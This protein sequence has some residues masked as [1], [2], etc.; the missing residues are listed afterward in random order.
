M[1]SGQHQRTRPE[2]ATLRAGRNNYDN[3]YM[4]AQRDY[5]GG[6]P[7]NIGVKGCQGSTHTVPA[8]RE[9]KIRMHS[10]AT[11][12]PQV[13]FRRHSLKHRQ[14][15]G[16][17]HAVPAHRKEKIIHHQ[18]LVPNAPTDHHNHCRHQCDS[19]RCMDHNVSCARGRHSRVHS[20][21]HESILAPARHLQGVATAH[22]AYV[23]LT[24]MGMHIAPDISVSISSGSGL[25]LLKKARRHSTGQDS[26]PASH[27]IAFIHHKQHT[28]DEWI[29]V[30]RKS[31]ASVGSQNKRHHSLHR[32][33]GSAHDSSN[34]SRAIPVHG[35]GKLKHHSNHVANEVADHHSYYRHQ[36]DTDDSMDQDISPGH[37][38]CEC[39]RQAR[40][41]P[42]NHQHALIKSSRNRPLDSLPPMNLEDVFR[43]PDSWRVKKHT[44]F[45]SEVHNNTQASGHAHAVPAHRETKIKRSHSCS[46]N[47][48]TDHH[49]HCRHQC[50]SEGCADHNSS[51]IHGGRQPIS[52]TR[53]VSVSPRQQ[54]GVQQAHHAYVPLT[55]TGLNV[56]TK[57]SIAK[58]RKK[59]YRSSVSRRNYSPQHTKVP[60]YGHALGGVS[61]KESSPENVWTIAIDKNH[62]HTHR[63]RS[64]RASQGTPEM[65]LD[66]LFEENDGN[67]S[68]DS[69]HDVAPEYRKG[70]RIPGHAHA[71]PAHRDIRL[72]HHHSH[73]PN[74][75]ADHHNHWRHQCDSEIC[76]DLNDSHAHHGHP[77]QK[78]HAHPV[79]PPLRQR[80]YVQQAHIANRV[81]TTDGLRIPTKELPQNEPK[82]RHHISVP[83]RNYG[84]Q[85]VETPEYVHEHDHPMD[86]THP[87][88]DSW[89]LAIDKNHKHIHRTRAHRPPVGTPEMHLDE[90]FTLPDSERKKNNGH[91]HAFPAH[92]E[93]RLKRHYS[94]IPNAPM[95]RHNHWRH[96]CEMEECMSHDGSHAHYGQ[97]RVA[98]HEPSS[99]DVPLRQ[100]NGIHKAHPAGVPLTSAGLHVP[101]EEPWAMSPKKKHHIGV[102]SRH[103]GAQHEKKPALMI[104]HTTEAEADLSS[105]QWILAIDKNHKHTHRTR[106]HRIQMGTPEMHLDEI[107]G[108][109][110]PVKAH[111]NEHHD[112]R[113]CDEVGPVDAVKRSSILDSAPML[114]ESVSWVLKERRQDVEDDLEDHRVLSNADTAQSSNELTHH[115]NHLAN[116]YMDRHNHRRHQRKSEYG[117]VHDSSHEHPLSSRLRCTPDSPVLDL[118][119]LF[120]EPASWDSMNQA[121]SFQGK[122]QTRGHAHAVPTHRHGKNKRN[123]YFLPNSPTDHHNH[124]RHRRDREEYADHNDIDSHRGQPPGHRSHHEVVA[125]VRHQR[126]ITQA[127][128]AGTPLV[129]ES[130]RK[131][132]HKHKKSH[133]RDHLEKSIP[134]SNSTPDVH[135]YMSSRDGNNDNGPTQYNEWTVVTHARSYHNGPRDILST[136]EN[137][138]GSLYTDGTSLIPK[139]IIVAELNRHRSYHTPAP[140]SSSDHAYIQQNAHEE[141]QSPSIHSFSR[142]SNSRQE[143][144]KNANAVPG[145]SEGRKSNHQLHYENNLDDHHNHHRQQCGDKYFSDHND[146]HVHSRSQHGDNASPARFVHYSTPHHRPVGLYDDKYSRTADSRVHSH[147]ADSFHGYV[148]NIPKSLEKLSKVKLHPGRH[149]FLRRRANVLSRFREVDPVNQYR[150]AGNYRAP[151]SVQHGQHG[152][153]SSYLRRP[154]LVQHPR[155]RHTAS[156]L[157]Q[158]YPPVQ[159][160][161]HH[162]QHGTSSPAGRVRREYTRVDHSPSQSF[163]HVEVIHK[164]EDEEELFK[165]LDR[166]PAHFHPIHSQ[167]SAEHTSI[168]HDD[169]PQTAP[170]SAPVQRAMSPQNEKEL[171][172]TRNEIRKAAMTTDD[173]L[174]HSHAS[175]PSTPVSSDMQ[176]P[177]HEVNTSSSTH[178]TR[179]PSLKKLRK[180]ARREYKATRDRNPQQTLQRRRSVLETMRTALSGVRMDL[181]EDMRLN[182]LFDEHESASTYTMA[183]A[184]NSAEALVMAGLGGIRELF[185]AALN[186]PIKVA[187]ALYPQQQPEYQH[188]TGH[189]TGVHSGQRHNHGRSHSKAVTL[190][191]TRSIKVNFSLFPEEEPDYPRESEPLNHHPE[192]WHENPA[193]PD[194]VCE[195]VIETPFHPPQHQHQHRPNQ[196]VKQGYHHLSASLFRA[197]SPVAMSSYNVPHFDHNNDHNDEHEVD[198]LL[199]PE[200]NTGYQ[201][202][203][204]PSLNEITEVPFSETSEDTS[205]QHPQQAHSYNHSK[206]I[207]LRRPLGSV[208]IFPEEDASY[209][210]DAAHDVGSSEY[211]PHVDD[212]IRLSRVYA[213]N[214]FI[215]RRPVHEIQLDDKDQHAHHDAHPTLVDLAAAAVAAGLE[216]FKAMLPTIHLP[217]I[218]TETLAPEA[219]EYSYAAHDQA[220]K[221]EQHEKEQKQVQGGHRG[222]FVPSEHH[223]R[224]VESYNMFPDRAS[225]LASSSLSGREGSAVLLPALLARSISVLPPPPLPKPGKEK[226][227]LSSSPSTWA[228]PSGDDHERFGQDLVNDETETW[229]KTAEIARD[230]YELADDDNGNN[231]GLDDISL[232]NA[233]YVPQYQRGRS[234]RPAQ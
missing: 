17:A 118:G 162:F 166:P 172:F 196:R 128:P 155:H 99:V 34:H 78:D 169:V 146:S 168:Y 193:H 217:E 56:T 82:M 87:E 225:K 13:R 54:H 37:D 107:F 66:E 199:Y 11:D 204:H 126:G 53:K 27:P 105:G 89:T 209:P 207:G 137:D 95:D 44:S 3:E 14:I 184:N 31:R 116:Q 117:L 121:S 9:D 123:N 201:N 153:A 148:F 226:N 49:N 79:H 112:T 221:E 33:S 67:S 232:Q 133:R 21:K 18:N 218:V 4:V 77:P 138:L 231:V 22:H 62:K 132:L 115:D 140:W 136:P 144:G 130:R 101:V 19:N 10:A 165:G 86:R 211:D 90:F 203:P 109:N 43:E 23:P 127:H 228:A 98:T 74:A 191:T 46:P 41:H 212:E 59:K 176:V 8:H 149:R 233:Q 55:T 61:E 185:G 68:D 134:A 1:N 189:D 152:L 114:K 5:G 131:S 160:H 91:A 195:R 83:S 178:P 92:K 143:N 135:S 141:H 124:W 75:P 181:V 122:P 223:C 157:Q 192:G 84:S 161:A 229:S 103:Y 230:Y 202:P 65:H 106:A 214:P 81:I 47:K 213:P 94:H 110:E 210:R 80:H 36:C 167:D 29:V 142:S 69:Q 72:K 216:S 28:E 20:P 187:H 129:S 215:R 205:E 100:Q 150:P 206:A 15:P 108:D 159:L 30:P 16:H 147:R 70:E 71:V 151:T 25:S 119:A 51:H 208:F 188:R 234:Q 194:S 42:S 40:K 12:K 125:P 2:A 64:L 24:S 45:I 113:S 180:E 76:I 190:K 7:E 58:S 197:S 220:Q 173:D 171:E 139:P 154:S 224:H 198:H 163:G 39:H 48:A 111:I 158:P 222:T 96:Q 175:G 183:P 182:D 35:D 170:Q 97:P 174:H 200:E 177:A 88:G 38:S 63:A 120:Q 164:D 6:A 227:R 93:H 73:V 26:L 85:H 32:I 57:E 186:I 104:E 156:Q 145:R 52:Q 219:L 179:R 102:P 60:S 50:D